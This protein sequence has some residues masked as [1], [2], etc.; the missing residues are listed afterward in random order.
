MQRS[1]A[2]ASSVLLAVLAVVAAG[3]VAGAAET[4]V[5]A[6]V[7]SEPQPPARIFG[8]AAALPGGTEM[9]VTGG[10]TPGTDVVM[11]VALEDTWVFDGETWTQICGPDGGLA[12][13]PI[14]NRQMAGMGTGPNGAVLFGGGVGDIGSNVQGDTWNFDGTTWTQVCDAPACGPEIR[15]GPAMAGNGSQ[16]V[17]FSGAG[18]GPLDDTWTFDGTAWT[19]VCGT[20]IA[21]PCG[22]PA[23]AGGALA[24]DGTQFVLFGGADFGTSELFDD[25]WTFDGTT[26]TQVCGTSIG[27]PCGPAARA[28]AGAAHLTGPTAALSGAVFGGGGNLFSEDG[29]PTL[30]RDLWL[31]RGGAWTQLTT[32][33]DSSPLILTD[34]EAP[35]VTTPVLFLLGALDTTCR[36]GLTGV[37][38]PDG[39]NFQSQTHVAG[40]DL[41]GTGAPSCTTAPP[42]PPP[43]PPPPAED[44]TT[45]PGELP[46][47]GR[48]T[49]ALAAW[50]VVC[51]AVGA[52]LAAA[53]RGRVAALGRG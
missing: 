14:G 11:P 23:R 41:A 27:N 22:P 47:T 15:F 29:T 17:L 44:G 19:Q 49:G 46:R 2:L 21:T 4:F 18:A 43:P 7:T 38:I 32:P 37:T 28:L 5:V 1:A 53:G 33:W 45:A 20:S 31:F 10:Q 12:A 3:P 25:T 40:W 16:V 30:Q 9:V 26:W 6:P 48:S 36:V 35:V 13:C 8:A 24:W 50:G 52:V 34:P 39:A 51:L 42:P